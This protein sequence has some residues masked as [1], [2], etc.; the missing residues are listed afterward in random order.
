MDKNLTEAIKA[1]NDIYEIR[2][3]ITEEVERNLYQ[4]AIRPL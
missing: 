3:N 1:L 4:L 2:N